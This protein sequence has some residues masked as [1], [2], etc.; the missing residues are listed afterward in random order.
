MGSRRLELVAR[1]GSDLTQGSYRSFSEFNLG[2]LNGTGIAILD[3]G[4]VIC[5]W[6]SYS[7]SENNALL[8]RLREP[9]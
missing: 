1:V 8:L 3:D 4:V 2:M 5:G 6:S 7:T 9:E